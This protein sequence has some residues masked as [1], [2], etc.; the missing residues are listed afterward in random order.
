MKTT[1]ICCVFNELSIAPR[2]LSKILQ[3][4]EKLDLELEIIIIDNSSFDGTREWLKTLK[5]P[6][7]LK[8]F[9]KKNIGKGGSIKKGIAKSSGDICVIFDLDGEYS[10]DDAL[11]G[12]DFMR[13]SNLT[14]L[15]A[16][17][18]LTG[19][20]KYIY[21]LNYVGVRFLTW[22]INFIYRVQL[23]DTA[24]G[25]KLLRTKFYKE[26][27]IWFNGFNVDFEIVCLALNRNASV[28][29]FEGSYNPRSKVQGK[30]INAFKDGLASIIAICISYLRGWL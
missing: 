2:V 20:K 26:Q 6:Y 4:L 11:K 15:L 24:T 19:E 28:K 29:E 30:K 5:H 7:I 13:N 8:I 18:T 21:Y 22:I 27:D 12:I 23:T 10:L 1:F 25:L 14:L 16:S 3:K 17:R 9:N